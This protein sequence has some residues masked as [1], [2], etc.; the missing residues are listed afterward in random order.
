MTYCLKSSTIFIADEKILIDTEKK[1]IRKYNESA[2]IILAHL[3][4][5]PLS[6]DEIGTRMCDEKGIQQL[7]S[8]DIA[9]FVAYLLESG[10]IVSLE[11]VD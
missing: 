1:A 10:L 4:D 2:C 9:A 6:L 7:C 5:G 8:D 3:E 11:R